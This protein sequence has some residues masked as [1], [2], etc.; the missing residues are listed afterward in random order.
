VHLFK[1]AKKLGDILV[2]AV[3]DDSSVKKI[4]G[5]SRPVFCL[6][7]RLEVLEAIEDIDYLTSFSDDNPQKLIGVIL[8]DVLVKGGD[9][10]PD[11]VIG[12]KE[13]EKTGGRVVIISWIKGSSTSEIIRRILK[14]AESEE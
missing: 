14:A 13:V 9:W 8:P 1:E 5:P 3:N 7:E 2:V 6:K 12:K 4:K 10:K 11:E